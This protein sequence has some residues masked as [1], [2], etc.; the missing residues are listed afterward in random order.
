MPAD[1]RYGLGPDAQ[2]RYAAQV[3]AVDAEAVLRV[4]RRV[5]DLEVYV[6]ASIR[7]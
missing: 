3:D 7:P 5:I 4:A 2:R 6:A 1:A